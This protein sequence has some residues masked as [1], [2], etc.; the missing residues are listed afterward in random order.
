MYPH[1]CVSYYYRVDGKE[2]IAT[3]AKKFTPILRLSTINFATT[4]MIIKRKHEIKCF[5]IP[6]FLT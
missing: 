6:K 5:S 3:A 1:L 2:L 4:I